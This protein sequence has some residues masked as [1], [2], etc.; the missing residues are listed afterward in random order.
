MRW[1]SERKRCGE[2]ERGTAASLCL[3]CADQSCSKLTNP[4]PVI[5]QPLKLRT[6]TRAVLGV[7][8]VAEVGA[9]E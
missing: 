8:F 3:T 7:E 4:E 2:D 9:P 5:A 1:W 6:S